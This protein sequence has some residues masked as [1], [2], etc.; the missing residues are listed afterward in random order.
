MNGC[1]GWRWGGIIREGGMWRVLGWGVQ[2]F[3]FRQVW[4]LYR[5]LP[6]YD[7]LICTFVL[8]GFLYS[9]CILPLK[10]GLKQLKK[11]KLF[12]ESLLLVNKLEKE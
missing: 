3:A 12:W 11:I 10:K 9:C 6:N 5:S 1:W 7:S 2:N 4:W 8:C